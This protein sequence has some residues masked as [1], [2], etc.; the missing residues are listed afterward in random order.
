MLYPFQS[1][2]SFQVAEKHQLREVDHNNPPLTKISQ[3]NEEDDEKD[4]ERNKYRD[5]KR[6][7][8][9]GR[10]ENICGLR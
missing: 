4:K 5:A 2:R 8:I 10:R 7:Q 9:W 3:E 6:F 1:E